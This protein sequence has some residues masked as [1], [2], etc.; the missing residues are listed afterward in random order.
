MAAGLAV[1]IT[2]SLL[3]C[4]A[5]SRR[6]DAG[7]A[8]Q[9][10]LLVMTTAA[11]VTLFTRAVAGPCATVMTLLPAGVDPHGFQARPADL[12]RLRRARVLVS[13]GLGLEPFLAPLVAAADNPDLKLVDSGRGLALPEAPANPH[14]W[15]D[16]ERA[17]RQVEAIG[18]AL[19]AADPACAAGYRQRASA[20][21]ARLRALDREIASRLAR[22]RGRSFVTSHAFATY[23]AHRYGLV[24]IAL[25]PTPEQEPAP[26]DLQRVAAAVR[27]GRLRAV[28]LPPGEPSRTLEALARD[29]G[30][31]VRP[32]D[33]LELLNE[34]QLRDPE[35]YA[36]LQRRNTGQLL[37]ALGARTD[38]QKP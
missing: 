10:R 28:L 12:L 32:F 18:E 21:G 31:G 20:Y 19:A 27:Q 36:T 1:V 7:D 16:P 4:E 14:A 3:A 24:A 33:T 26:A 25:Q 38:P 11:P 5:R 30:V 6:P 9:T 22:V 8:P 23:Y 15:L 35:S 29:L 2:L 13:N 37:E 34:A 17:R